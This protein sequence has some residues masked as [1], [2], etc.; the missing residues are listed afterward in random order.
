[1]AKDAPKKERKKRVKPSFDNFKDAA[2]SMKGYAEQFLAE[3]DKYEEKG[4]KA[5]LKRARKEAGNLKKFATAFRK[6]VGEELG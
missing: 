4:T 5:A 1:M 6:Q 3:L 2:K